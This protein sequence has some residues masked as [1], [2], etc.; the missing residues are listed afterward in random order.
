MSANSNDIYHAIAIKYRVDDISGA[1]I[2]GAKLAKILQQIEISKDSISKISLEF[3][4]MRQMITLSRFIKNE[5]SYQEFVTLATLEQSERQILA[6]RNARIEFL[7]K[8]QK[9]AERQRKIKEMFQDLKAQKHAF[10]NDPKIIAKRK[11]QSLRKKYGIMDYIPESDFSRLMEILRRLDRGE[12]L[13]EHDVAW[14]LEERDGYGSDYYTPDIRA[15]YHRIEA[16]FY[17]DEYKRNKDFWCVVNASSH[18]RKS[19][20]SDIANSLLSSIDIDSTNKIKLKSALCTT[21]GGVKKDLKQWDEALNFGKQAHD[22]TPRDFRPCTLLGAVN[23]E[24]GDYCNG[25]SWYEKAL[26]RGASEKSI[27]DDLK[28][29]FLRLEKSKQDALRA[30]LL[31]KDSLRYSWAKKLKHKTR[32]EDRY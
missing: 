4:E 2:P 27:D 13:S 17:V 18:Y 26:R 16:D 1:L 15:C 10:E 8:Q 29:I 6:E 12:R 31:E 11:G 28:K 32:Y 9:E 19:L 5:L 24:V 30:H 3:L 7:A 21:F 14:L 23:F 20:Q 25:H 22:L